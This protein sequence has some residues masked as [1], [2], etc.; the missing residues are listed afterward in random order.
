MNKMNKIYTYLV[1]YKTDFFLVITTKITLG[2]NTKSVHLHLSIHIIVKQ[3]LNYL[4]STS[5][6]PLDLQS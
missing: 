6:K 3:R 4:R 2:S 1:D 5:L